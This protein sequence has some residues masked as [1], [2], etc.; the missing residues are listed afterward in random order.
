[1]YFRIVLITL[2]FISNYTFSQDIFHLSIRFGEN[3]SSKD[4]RILYDNG[5][6]E[7]EIN[8]KQNKIMISDTLFS[9]YAKII[10]KLSDKN[11]V[12]APTTIRYFLVP[13]GYS[14]IIMFSK[15]HPPNDSI[16]F[17]LK[18]VLDLKKE[19][20]DNYKIFIKKEEESFSKFKIVNAEALKNNE[21]T[22]ISKYSKLHQNLLLR[23]YQFVKEN[24]DFFYSFI[25][26]D[27]KLRYSNLETDSLIN[28][29]N[30]SFSD[31]IKESWLG[32]KIS[33]FLEAKNLKAG[34]ISPSINEFDLNGDQIRL[35]KDKKILIFFWATWCKPCLEEM[36]EI[37]R[38]RETFSEDQLE[39]IGVSLDK[40]KEM[41]KKFV[42]D[43]KMNWINIIGSQDIINKFIVTGIPEV[44]LIINGKI[45]YSRREEPQDN[46]NKLP[47]LNKKLRSLFNRL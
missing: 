39:I 9:I 35:K 25:L 23:T 37:K 38:I 15:N 16:Y 31:S 21:V 45:A 26:F 10:F 6:K 1:M 27:E 43:S 19:G 24:P 3:V 20:E 22:A 34:S 47:V 2:L 40:N 29:Y 28:L 13:K 41:V 12:G 44:F 32:L 17:A 18:N 36:P 46:I 14:E 8:C 7:S 42:S 11:K 33:T 30:E 4:V 5:K